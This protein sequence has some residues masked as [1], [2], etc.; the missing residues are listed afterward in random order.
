M[1][2][3]SQWRTRV[4][5]SR[6]TNRITKTKMTSRSTSTTRMSEKGTS[7]SAARS[8]KLSL[9]APGRHGESTTGIQD[10][11]GAHF[12]GHHREEFIRD[13]R[14]DAGS[15]LGLPAEDLFRLGP[16]PRHAIRYSKAQLVSA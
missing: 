13:H 15:P 8:A 9:P 10:L 3:R 1:R 7:N 2:I 11:A 4:G 5:L 14:L 12:Y 6:S 16:L